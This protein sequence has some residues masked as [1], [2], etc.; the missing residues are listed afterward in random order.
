MGRVWRL[1]V[2]LLIAGALTLA[3]SRCDG[4]EDLFSFVPAKA[5]THSANI[6]VI[7]QNAWSEAYFSPRAVSQRR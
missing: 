4:R 6:L 2:G 7:Q 5:G 3:L 1:M